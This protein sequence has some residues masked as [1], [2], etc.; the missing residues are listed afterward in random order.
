M[1][2]VHVLPIDYQ[3]IEVVE[4]LASI[5]MGVPLEVLIGGRPS[6][7]CR[8]VVDQLRRLPDEAR[9]FAINAAR[10]DSE[11]GS[12]PRLTRSR[13][14]LILQLIANCTLLSL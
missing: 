9:N 1:D 4:C 6:G 7:S 3:G 12:I 14:S 11:R 10:P 13:R 2:P 5:L 8:G